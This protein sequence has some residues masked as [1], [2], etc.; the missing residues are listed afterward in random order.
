MG[1]QDC[2][3]TENL[4]TMEHIKGYTRKLTNKNSLTDETLKGPCSNKNHYTVSYRDSPINIW[5]CSI[6]SFKKHFLNN[7]FLSQVLGVRKYCLLPLRIL[8]Q[9]NRIKKKNTVR[10]SFQHKLYQSEEIPFYSYFNEN[11][12][13]EWMST[14]LKWFFYSY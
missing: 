11:F 2:R 7:F 9:K 10:W 1:S 13:Q 4:I 8:L 3:F 14:S 6:F 5:I 12:C